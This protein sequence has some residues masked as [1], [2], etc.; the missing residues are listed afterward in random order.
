MIRS[1]YRL[2]VSLLVMLVFAIT[3]LPN[4]DRSGGGRAFAAGYAI[5]VKAEV[6]FEGKAK[7]SEWYP[8]TVTLR[9]GGEAVTG[10]VVLEMG[11]PYNTSGDN[12]AY[13][14]YLELPAG[15]EKSVRFVVPGMVLTPGNNRIS[16]FEGSFAKGKRIPFSAG[17]DWAETSVSRQLL[18]GVIARDPDTLNFLAL[19]NQKNF[20][21]DVVH[22]AGDK[23]PDDALQLQGLNMIVFNDTATDTLTEA[24]TKALVAWTE[25]GGQLVLAGGAGY[26]KTAKAFETIAPVS[27]TGMSTAASLESLAHAAGKELPLSLP[28]P[29][30][31]AAL[32]AGS[33]L[34]STD[35]LPLVAR[36]TYGSGSVW[37]IAYDLA[38]EPVASWNGN[39]DL[40]AR[41]LQSLATASLVKIGRTTGISSVDAMTEINYALDWF[42]SISPPSLDLL[43]LLFAAYALL[44]APLLYVLLKKLDKREWAWAVIPAF[45]ILFSVGVYMIGASKKN[46]TITHTLSTIELNDSGMGNRVSAMALFVPRGGRYTIEMPAGTRLLPFDSGGSRPVTKVSETSDPVVAE[47]PAG[48]RLSFK[49]IPYWST[50]KTAVAAGNNEPYGKFEVTSHV[51]SNG[52]GGE[53][54]NRTQH[55]MKHV[56]VFM[57]MRAVEIGDLKAGESKPFSLSTGPAGMNAF[58]DIGSSLFPNASGRNDEFV[59]ERQMAETYFSRKLNGNAAPSNA[60][61]VIGW[62]KDSLLSY[63]VNGSNAKSDQLNMWV[64]QI[65]PKFVQGSAVQIPYGYL[66]P[67]VVD[68]NLQQLFGVP[69]NNMTIGGGDFTF[70]YRL[71]AI[72]GNVQYTSLHM[73]TDNTA[74]AAAMQIWNEASR[75]WIPFVWQAGGTVDL[76]DRLNELLVEG[77]TIRIKASSAQ[78]VTFQYPDV[79]LEGTVK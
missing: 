10:E 66:S 79:A 69:G 61:Y 68:N 64:Q 9:N 34:Y 77:R 27:Y 26:P 28:F 39:A 65:E 73:R 19:L 35:G 42:P 58:Y 32:K 60:P 71:P 54:V 20:D 2:F 33:T 24:Q 17:N 3:V 30:S 37:Y 18:I 12:L 40:W 59:R 15:S 44:V 51:D 22:M 53:I 11:S 76:S 70:E 50:R 49:R 45:S 43:L 31:A 25:R 23:L 1:R 62:S 7:E 46:A 72:T 55:D 14:Q 36:Q 8:L 4:E 63:K 21:L 16:F 74:N 38:L 47:S 29:I 48:P 75:S 67:V 13:T 5:E 57:N 78:T 52:L 56:A 6:G 41:V